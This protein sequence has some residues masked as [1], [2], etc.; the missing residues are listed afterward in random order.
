MQ[1]RVGTDVCLLDNKISEGVNSLG[2]I[3][4]TTSNDAIGITWSLTIMI[5]FKDIL[6][7]APSE[8]KAVPHL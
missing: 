6:I 7:T 8:N 1:Q 3:E 2:D 4:H 5:R